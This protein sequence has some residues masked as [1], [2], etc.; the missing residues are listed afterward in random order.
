M[1]L[2]FYAMHRRWTTKRPLQDYWP[3]RPLVGEEGVEIL[4][5]QMLTVK[6][7]S[8][9]GGAGR[10]GGGPLGQGWAPGRKGDAGRFPLALQAWGAQ[11]TAA[12]DADA[13]GLF[14][15]Q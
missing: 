6:E 7:G 2:V 3:H 14:L 12:C 10:E 15:R 9:V 4:G 13:R 11:T 1:P 8:E 5:V